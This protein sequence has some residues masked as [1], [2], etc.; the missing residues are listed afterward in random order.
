MPNHSTIKT[1]PKFES[2]KRD[3]LRGAIEPRRPGL[4]LKDLAKKYNV[5]EM[6]LR[7]FRKHDLIRECQAIRVAKADLKKFGPGTTVDD[8]LTSYAET[9]RHAANEAI[10]SKK[11]GDVA[12]LLEAGLNVIMAQARNRGRSIDPLP[13]G[14]DDNG[15]AVRG[16]TVNFQAIIGTPKTEN[17]RVHGKDGNV[18]VESKPLLEEPVEV[19]ELP[20]GMALGD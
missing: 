11:Y 15:L 10:K 20:D 5:G 9:G 13:Q 7:R 4:M 3:L 1:H 6:A 16:G 2:I 8:M 19:E 14:I 17:G 18:I 12:G